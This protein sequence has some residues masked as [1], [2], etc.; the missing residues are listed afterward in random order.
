MGYLAT[1][2]P[3]RYNIPVRA[4]GLSSF[5]TADNRQMTRKRT[6]PGP[7]SM[8]A[9]GRR[10]RAVVTL[11]TLLILPVLL[12]LFAVAVEGVHF[13]LA[14]V[15]LENALEAAA[16]AAVKDWA[17][18]GSAPGPGWTHPARIVGQQYAAANTINQTPVSIDTNLGV[19]DAASNPNENL[20]FVGDLVFGAV[21]G[22]HPDYVFEV[23]LAPSCTGAAVGGFQV[24]QG[25]GAGSRVIIDATSDRLTSEDNGWGISFAA[26]PGDDLQ[27]VLIERIVIDIDPNQTENL[28]F[29]FSKSGQP[30]ILS[31]SRPQ[32]MVQ[33]V[34]PNA[35]NLLVHSEQPDNYG[36]V[37]WFYQTSPANPTVPPG[38]VQQWPGPNQT[39]PQIQFSS[40]ADPNGI[41]RFLTIDFFPYVDEF[42]NVLD[43]GFEPGD[44]FRFGAGVKRGQPAADGDD[45]GDEGVSVTVFFSNASQG[46][47]TS[48]VNTE[49]SR[50]ECA[51]QQNPGEW[52]LDALDNWHLLV[53]PVRL[54]PPGTEPF[55]ARD[56][57][58]PLTNQPRNDKQSVAAAFVPSPVA[59]RNYAVRAQARHEV[60]S[61]ICRF[62]NID[63]GGPFSIFACT[64]AMYDCQLQRPRLIRA[65]P[66]GAQFDDG[67][68]WAYRDVRFSRAGTLPETLV[69][70]VTQA[71]GGLT[72]GELQER[73]QTPVANL[74][75]RSNRS[76]KR[77]K[78]QASFRMFRR[79]AVT[80]D[81]CPFFFFPSGNLRNSLGSYRGLRPQ[82]E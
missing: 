47:T 29:D 50:R 23:D 30:P 56:L 16:L 57:P 44:R 61:L 79:S 4:V 66:M 78:G 36:F 25:G 39:S 72:A 9:C 1:D 54:L 41:A 69:A 80:K 38:T 22:E 82:P 74:L 62:L 45:I 6:V 28:V 15:E 77:G 34:A 17:E 8:R 5:R 20:A 71:P 52:E 65:Q 51:R 12:V 81:A 42:G 70:L 63:F 58:C 31:D 18:S 11:W 14:R 32:T 33:G 21:T 10:R 7:T 75:S 64:T 3:K 40:D 76:R 19:F 59:A 37:G 2:C 27:G 43:A 53:H 73:W 48:F 35:D 60:P 55:P 26:F 13:W 46:V 67:G 68:L 24:V 49:Y